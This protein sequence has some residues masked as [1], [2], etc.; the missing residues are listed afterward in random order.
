MKIKKVFSAILLGIF[1]IA[2]LYSGEAQAA[3]SG[4]IAISN[5]T[6]NVGSTVTIT[7]ILSASANIYA[8]T[9]VLTYPTGGLEFVSGS[10]DV[11][12]GSGSVRF[13]ADVSGQGKKSVS[14]NVTFRILKEGTHRIAGTS[15]SSY[16][17]DIEQIS[18]SSGAGTITGKAQTTNNSQG[19]GNTGTTIKPNTNKPGNNN[20]NT[21]TNDPADNKDKNSKLNSLQVSPG[22]LAPVFSADTTSYTVAVPESTTEVTIAATAQ[23]DKATVSVTGGKDL[24]HGENEAKVVVMA[25]SGATTVYNITILCGEES[26]IQVDGEDYTINEAFTDEQIPVGFAREK[27]TYNDRE[28]EALKHEKGELYLVNLQNDEAGA[29]FYIYDQKTQEFYHYAQV[30]FQNG[31]YIIPLWLDNTKEFK[32]CEMITLTLQD[33]QFDAWK[34]D[35]EYSVIRVMNSDG[36]ITFYQYDNIDGTLQRYGKSVAK[37]IE[38]TEEKE[39]KIFSLLKEYHLYII[40]GLSV[41]VLILAV[42]L[43]YFMATRKHRHQAR[44]RKMQKK[45]EK[46]KE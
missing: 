8:T 16:T 46:Q 13:F 41:L 45:L 17:E 40:A 30:D 1:I 24:K 26:K 21:T 39:G 18:V 43:I 42:V 31:R 37:E 23:S 10:S 36:E 34:I 7:C 14:F 12:G 38:E 35:E 2:T 5:G 15:D 28:Y 4:S 9:V 19:G 44:R 6:G 33:K 22:T 3:A 25:E 11:T 32:Q 27:V 29:E 20:N